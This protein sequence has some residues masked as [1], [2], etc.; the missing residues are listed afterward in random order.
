ML[1][2]NDVT[3]IETASTKQ[4]IV[5]DNLRPILFKKNIVIPLIILLFQSLI[6]SSITC[7][8]KIRE[9]WIRRVIQPC[10]RYWPGKFY[11]HFRKLN[12]T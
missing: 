8:L 5:N 10:R 1:G 7:H 6:N 12:Q 9:D 4:L 2:E 3:V 11:I